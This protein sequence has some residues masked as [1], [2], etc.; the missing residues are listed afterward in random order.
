MRLIFCMSYTNVSL[1]IHSVE[2]KSTP[3]RIVV[4]KIQLFD[5]FSGVYGAE[6]CYLLPDIAILK[7]NSW[8]RL[9]SWLRFFSLKD[10]V[11]NDF[12]AL[13]PTRLYFFF[14]G[15]SEFSTWLI[16]KLSED[17][18]VFYGPAVVANVVDDRWN[19]KSY[20]KVVVMG[21]I[22]PAKYDRIYNGSFYYNGVS[23]S[24]LKNIGARKVDFDVDNVRVREVI[25]KSESYNDVKVILA[26]GGEFQVDNEVFTCVVHDLVEILVQRFGGGCV[27][28]KRHPVWGGIHIEA[29]NA[30]KTIP[31]NLPVSIFFDKDTIVISLYSA[32]IFEAAN[33]G[34]LAISLLKC[35][36]MDD[37]SIRENYLNYLGS[38]LNEGANIKFPSSLA[39]L[40]GILDVVLS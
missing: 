29:E 11:L 17:T 23:R 15:Y 36:R 2:S 13:K 16:K 7:V 27:A 35:V 31:K 8:W 20:L 6:N 40:N 34:A 39:E 28:I 26:I 33:M 1:V 21:L 14:V 38:N 37:E 30:L 18:D 24:Y 9:S 4:N 10:K 32:V 22:F 19:F 12:L 25:A 3:F 5:L